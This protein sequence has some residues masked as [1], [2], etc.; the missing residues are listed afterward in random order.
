MALPYWHAALKAAGHM[1][2]PG[3]SVTLYIPVPTVAMA[4]RTRRGLRRRTGLACLS[5]TCD[6]CG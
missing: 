1:P 2:G 4:L 6:D 3:Q 5:W